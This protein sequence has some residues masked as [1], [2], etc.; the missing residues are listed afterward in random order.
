MTAELNFS[1]AE[2]NKSAQFIRG[3]KVKC[4]WIV[5]TLVHLDL[6]SRQDEGSSQ[7]GALQCHVL[8]SHLLAL[9]PWTC[10]LAGLGLV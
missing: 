7:F 3:K 9:G 6:Y 5:M 4:G 1:G 2:L 8:L 10:Y